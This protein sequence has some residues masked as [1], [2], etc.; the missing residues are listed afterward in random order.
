MPWVELLVLA[1]MGGIFV[2]SY[3][4][5]AGKNPLVPLHDPRLH[6]ALNY[7]NP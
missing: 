6:E 7:D 3:F 1:G 2:A 5:V 4:L